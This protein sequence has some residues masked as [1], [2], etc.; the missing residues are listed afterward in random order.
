[1]AVAIAACGSDPKPPPKRDD[2]A[3]IGSSVG[4]IV[5]QC[6]S[7]DAGFI[8]EPDTAQLRRDVN[9]LLAAVDRVDPDAEYKAGAAP[10]PTRRTS[11]RGELRLARRI[12]KKCDPALAKRLDAAIKG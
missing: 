4:D 8:A 2:I 6:Q 9:A 5:Y 12:L 7:V 3:A 11:V 10:G 1:M